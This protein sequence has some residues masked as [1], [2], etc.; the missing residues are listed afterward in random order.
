MTR[1]KNSTLRP[2]ALD[3]AAPGAQVTVNTATKE[4][5]HV[6]LTVSVRAPPRNT[7]DWK[8]VGIV[9]FSVGIGWGRTVGRFGCFICRAGREIRWYV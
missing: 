9:T 7:S 5:G 1:A 3:L 8:A 6:Q 2:F 4:D